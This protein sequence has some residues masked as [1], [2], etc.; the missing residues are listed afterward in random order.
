MYDL[1]KTAEMIAERYFKLG[2]ETERRQHLV[3][4][5]ISALRSERQRASVAAIW[6]GRELGEMAIGSD[7]GQTILDP[8]LTP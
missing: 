2:L 5:I 1:V 3:D 4:D 6:R 7:I 8:S